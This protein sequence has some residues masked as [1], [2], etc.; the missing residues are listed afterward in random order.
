MATRRGLRTSL[1]FRCR[2]FSTVSP[3]AWISELRKLALADKKHAIS[4]DFTFFEDQKFEAMRFEFDPSVWGAIDLSSALKSGLCLG[5]EQRV[6]TLIGEGFSFPDAMDNPLV[7]SP[8]VPARFWWDPSSTVPKVLVQ[9]A[10]HFPPA[11]WLPVKPEYDALKRVFSEFLTVDATIMERHFLYY[12]KLQ[13]E[14][15]KKAGQPLTEIQPSRMR[16]L[17]IDERRKTDPKTIVPD[18]T[19]ESSLYLGH[20]EH[21]RKIEDSFLNN[22]FVFAWPILLGSENH[23][24][25]DEMQKSAMFRTIYSKSI[26]VVEGREDLQFDPVAQPEMNISISVPIFLK[27]NYPENKR[28]CGGAQM[29]QRFNR[30][31]GCDHA[32]DTPVDVLAATIG[33]VV[34]GTSSLRDDL[35]DFAEAIEKGSA[36]EADRKQY[37]S[38][39][40]MLITHLAVLR[41]PRWKEDVLHRFWKSEP[42]D[43]R[44]ACAKGAFEMG[45]TDSLNEMLRTERDTHMIQLLTHL[46][47]HPAPSR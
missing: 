26:L 27:V 43:L 45:L 33:N 18:W 25:L 13:S 1:R 10:P 46:L 5:Q 15:E 42:R 14:M 38:A 44:I 22:P 29:V 34:R 41:D 47:A 9:L 40:A 8:S 3:P 30:L 2:G 19:R 16:D 24:Q 17:V 11:L 20:V 31:F 6:Y 32:L 12:E 21:F 39:L 37:H 28:M 23:H 4:Y 36:P 35:E 7:N